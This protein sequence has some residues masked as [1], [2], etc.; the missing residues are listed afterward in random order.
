MRILE[1]SFFE[2]THSEIDLKVQ[3]TAP[4]KVLIY[5]QKDNELPAFIFISQNIITLFSKP[6]SAEVPILCKTNPI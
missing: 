3:H 2:T 1:I 5:P 6:L 4:A